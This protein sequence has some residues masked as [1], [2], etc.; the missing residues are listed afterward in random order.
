MIEDI[1]GESGLRFRIHALPGTIAPELGHT[2]SLYTQI[3][4]VSRTEEDREREIEEGEF[5]STSEQYANYL[6]SKNE[7]ADV[8]NK[9]FEEI[10]KDKDIN[11]AD[12]RVIWSPEQG[13]PKPLSV[14]FAYK[15]NESGEYELYIRDT[16]G[17]SLNPLYS[18]AYGEKLHKVTNS[19][20]WMTFAGMSYPSG[21]LTLQLKDKNL[22]SAI[23][24]KIIEKKVECNGLKR[25]QK[26]DKEGEG[27]DAMIDNFDML[28]G[29][30]PYL[31]DAW[32]ILN[33][34]AGEM[35]GTKLLGNKYSDLDALCLALSLAV[36]KLSA[37]AAKALLGLSSAGAMS[38]ALG[39][40]SRAGYKQTSKSLLNIVKAAKELETKKIVKLTEQII[41]LKVLQ[42]ADE[43][44]QKT[45]QI[46]E[47]LRKL[48]WAVAGVPNKGIAAD[49]GKAPVKK[50]GTRTTPTQTEEL[51]PAPVYHEAGNVGSGGVSK[52]D[53]L[54]K[55][56]GQLPSETRVEGG[57]DAAKADGVEARSLDETERI[58]AEEHAG[59]K[60]DQLGK[61][62]DEPEYAKQAEGAESAKV[63]EAEGVNADE[64]ESSQI[65]DGAEVDQATDSKASTKADENAS[66]GKVEGDG[67]KV[68]GG[69]D[70]A[71]AD[72][73]EEPKVSNESGLAAEGKAGK[74]SE[75]EEVEI[76]A[77]KQGEETQQKS[78]RLEGEEL[79]LGFNPDLDKVSEPPA[80]ATDEALSD[81]EIVALA[82]SDFSAMKGSYTGVYKTEKEWIERYTKE[83][84]RFDRTRRVWYKNELKELEEPLTK[85][86][87][88]E[89]A[90]DALKTNESRKQYYE[91]LE[92][93]GY[94]PQS[95]LKDI[96]L[97]E[98]RPN[99][100]HDDLRH[101]MDAE[102]LDTVDWK[103]QAAEMEDSSI[104]ISK[105][106]AEEIQKAN[107]YRAFERVVKDMP[108]G[109]K[110]NLTEKWYKQTHG[111]EGSI[112][113]VEVDAETLKSIPNKDRTVSTRKL[114][115]V[116]PDGTM[117]E[118]KNISESIEGN[119]KLK[120]Q[121]DDYMGL[122]GEKLNVGGK[123]I[124][125]KRVVYT[126]VGNDGA[127]ANLDWMRDQLSLS[128]NKERL[129]FELILDNGSIHKLSSPGDVLGVKI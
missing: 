25:Q 77:T 126:I 104:D 98:R 107:S 121:F 97:S 95:K 10:E 15:S 112:A 1:P 74:A 36:P 54:A 94:N 118:V 13:Q 32:D 105:R 44:K 90:F 79:E 34:A 124:E 87:N 122:V 4:F 5:P 45:T 47:R 129:Q 119:P 37:G 120:S 61:D 127:K 103:K 88:A 21:T 38:K 12:V 83:G 106:S 31:G 24:K 8:E 14:V 76:G 66:V 46:V 85:G 60:Q 29:S 72:G 100:I 23:Q 123:K 68:E 117:R 71:K 113:H 48:K 101:K 82:V 41:D 49:Y 110:G 80:D 59:A 33:V 125:G 70:A 53:G 57:A 55:E 78:N 40:L 11:L 81:A 96:K 65:A 102:V 16:T 115:F 58:R 3:D 51:Y 56:K 6:I 84:Y 19:V 91:A 7:G 17:S 75:G 63:E 67:V 52:A 114:D 26:A 111:T 109:N 35:T 116:D 43:I 30:I 108:P 20:D 18:L 73:V 92:N 93:S 64:P 99:N 86:A 2:P 28:M 62:A 22:P 69:A 27:Q 42:K 89:E 39:R 9:A 128:I 50:F